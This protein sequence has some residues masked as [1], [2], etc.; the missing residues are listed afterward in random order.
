[1]EFNP[2][3]LPLRK[4]GKLKKM[5]LAIKICICYNVDRQKSNNKSM[6]TKNEIPEPC[7]TT[8]RGFFFSFYSGK[9][10]ARLSVALVVTI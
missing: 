5:Y 7:C 9:A 10:P 3:N 1:M 8:V 4:M 6:R 2:A